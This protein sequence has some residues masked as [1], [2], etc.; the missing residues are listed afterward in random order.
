MTTLIN[1]S[2]PLS[3]EAKEQTEVDYVQGSML[4]VFDVA[5][6]VDQS[7]PLAP[8]VGRIVDQAIELAGGRLNIDMIV[9]PGLASVAVLVAEALPTANILRLVAAPGVTPPKFMPVELIRARYV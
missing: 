5:V 1:F 3:L 6:Q 4:R 8:Q 9:L 7:V 2:H